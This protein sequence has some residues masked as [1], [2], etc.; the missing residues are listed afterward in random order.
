MQSRYVFVLSEYSLQEIYETALC[1]FL[2]A[3][4]QKL[5]ATR[6]ENIVHAHNNG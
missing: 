1:N 3:E 2:D 4:L 5:E 6:K